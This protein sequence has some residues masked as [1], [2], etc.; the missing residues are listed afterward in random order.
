M[1]DQSLTLR[2]VASGV[3]AA[4]AIT[5]VI[6]LT[7]DRLAAFDIVGPTLPF[8]YPWR[9]TEPDVGGQVSAWLGYVAHNFFV[10]FVIAKARA[11]GQRFEA[12]FTRFNYLML[13]GNGAF[14]ALHLLQTHVFYDGL[15]RDVPEITALGSVAL[16]LIVI[17]YFEAP[18]RG[19]AFG[20]LRIDRRFT[21]IARAYHGYLFSWAIIY[22]FWYHPMES[23]QGHLIGFF[24]MFL[25]M[26]QSVLILN[27]AHINRTWTLVLEVMVI[28]HA[29]L[30]AVTQPANAWRMF[31]FGFLVIFIVT[32][33]HGVGWSRFVRVGLGGTFAIALVLAYGVFGEMANWHEV[34]RI[35]MVDYL[36][37]ALLYVGCRLVV[38]IRP[39]RTNQSVLSK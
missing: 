17:L 8:Q 34:L 19:L 15:A 30:V 36:V 4:A 5:L 18:R 29:I 6:A 9:L 3:V 10:W 24:Y 1:N 28:P 20:A 2:Y 12:S 21:E 35:P 22:T 38:G 32:Q 27:R 26:W 16:M 23:T 14:I 13:W 7:G 11:S 39:G 31:G 37:V 33:M 25:L